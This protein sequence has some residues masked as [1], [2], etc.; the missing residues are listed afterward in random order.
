MLYLEKKVYKLLLVAKKSPGKKFKVSE[1]MVNLL[2]KYFKRAFLAFNH[3][4]W[5]LQDFQGRGRWH[6][7]KENTGYTLHYDRFDPE[8]GFEYTLAHLMYDLSF[9]EKMLI[10]SLFSLLMKV[11]LRK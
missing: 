10:L 6:L 1:N 11:L 3:E 7:E 2:K 4:S 8:R 9:P 5:T